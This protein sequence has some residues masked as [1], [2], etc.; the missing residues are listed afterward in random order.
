MKKVELY[1]TTL[2]DGAQSEGISYSV[3]D[4]VAITKQLDRLGIQYI[5]GGWPVSNPKELE[6]FK[7]AKSLKLKN[8]E[9]VAFGSTRKA[10]T[11]TADDVNIKALV[12]S[13]VKTA[14]IF[15]KSWDFHVKTALKTTLD[16]NLKM[17]KDSVSYLKSKGMKVIYD[18]EHFFDGFKENPDYALE[19]LLAACDGGAETIVLCDTNGGTVTSDVGKI[20]ETVSRSINVKLGIHAHNDCEMAVASSIAAVEA[21]CEHVQGTMNGYGERCGN[22][23]LVS[24]IPILKLKL[25][26]DCISNA[27]LKELTEVSRYVDEISNVKHQ[28]NQPFVG[29]SAF[30]HKAG[31][32]INAMMKNMKTYEHTNPELVGNK[33]RFLVSELSGKTSILIKAKELKMDLKKDSPETKKILALLQKLEH[34]G[35]HF[36]AAQGSFELMMKR[37]LDKHKKFFELEG[38]KVLVERRGKKLIS[39]AT[40]KLKVKGKVQHTAAEGDGPVNALDNALRKALVNFYPTLAEMHLS[41]FRVRVLDE[42]TGTAA[43]VRVLIESQDAKRSWW[44]IGV[45]ENI[46]EASWQAL[47]DS[48][49]YKLAKG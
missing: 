27:Q 40:M 21:G 1:D 11:K 2:R 10:K 37:A 9:V 15:G 29:Q 6:F 31:V 42:K 47:T 49:E 48:V 4:K 8:A 23:N 13:G 3:P 7:K 19:A 24:I 30:A 12:K 34:K 16:E 38:F 33:R 32:H 41:D 25:G 39:E 14:C 20:V 5:E 36:E 44:T 18:A 43:K 45:S 46:I 28:D 26:M 17:I 35:Y 22:A